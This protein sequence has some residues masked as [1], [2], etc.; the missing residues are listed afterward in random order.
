MSSTDERGNYYRAK[1]GRHSASVT[2]PTETYQALKEYALQKQLSLSGS[3]CH[4][5]RQAFNQTPLNQ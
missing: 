2:M 1:V 5:L 3:I 4:L